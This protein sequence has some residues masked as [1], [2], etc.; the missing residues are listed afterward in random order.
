MSPTLPLA[1][2]MEAEQ[3]EA[4]TNS[5][6]PQGPGAPTIIAEV[7]GCQI[8][9][10]TIAP[11][12]KGEPEDDRKRRELGWTEA[13]LYFILPAGRGWGE[14]RPPNPVNPIV[15]DSGMSCLLAG[16]RRRVSVINCGLANPRVANIR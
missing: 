7:D 15:K 5:V 8:P 2:V 1:E 10:V 16:V 14:G 4:K 9:V 6:L 12:E 3:N 11:Q 13:R